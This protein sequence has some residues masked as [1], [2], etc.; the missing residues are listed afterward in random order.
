MV[1]FVELIRY[2]DI[3]RAHRIIM[4]ITFKI[5]M[6]LVYT[7]SLLYTHLLTSSSLLSP[8]TE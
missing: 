3:G 2:I 7:P 8:Y 4:P 6:K 5:L 1:K